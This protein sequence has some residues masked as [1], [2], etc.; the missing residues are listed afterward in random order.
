MVVPSMA[1]I[2]RLP[3]ELR[4]EIYRCLCRD[5]FIC[6][7]FCNSPIT[8]INLE[9]PPRQLLLTCHQIYDEVRTYYYGTATFRLASIGTSQIKREDISAGTLIALGE[10]RK[11]ELMLMWNMNGNRKKRGPSSWPWWMNGWLEEQV[12]LL[13]DVA[14]KLEVVAIAVRD[15]S[16]YR[17][18]EQKKPMLEPLQLLKGKI[19]FAVT[20][21]IAADDIEENLRQDIE[22]YVRELNS[23]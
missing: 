21:V 1:P 10:A 4:Y 6:Y 20:E 12:A 22:G 8:A 3:V 18:W 2:F 15:A 16:H 19:Q 17:D 5:E 11:V 14:H 13:R 23:S 9:A 7:P